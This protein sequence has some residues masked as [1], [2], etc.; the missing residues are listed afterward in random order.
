[1]R[2]RLTNEEIELIQNSISKWDMGV[3]RDILGL[4]C[5]FE[6]RNMSLDKSVERSFK[7]WLKI[8]NSKFNLNIIF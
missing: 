3:A 2:M 8:Q 4:G 1:M 6:F 7:F 5:E